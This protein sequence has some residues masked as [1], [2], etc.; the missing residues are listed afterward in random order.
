MRFDG[1]EMEAFAAVQ[2]L[3]YLGT[4][5]HNNESCLQDCLAVEKRFHASG[6][7]RMVRLFGAF[8]LCEEVLGEFHVAMAEQFTIASMG[9]MGMQCL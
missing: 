3:E 8:S 7:E 5:L 2:R 6:L 1:L 4:P 9:A